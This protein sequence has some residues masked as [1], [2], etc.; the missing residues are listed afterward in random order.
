MRKKEEKIPLWNIPPAGPSGQAPKEHKFVV[1]DYFNSSAASPFM[2]G[3]PHWENFLCIVDKKYLPKL[4][5]KTEELLKK[6]KMSLGNLADSKAGMKFVYQ[7]K[8]SIKP[9]PKFFFCKKLGYITD[10]AIVYIFVDRNGNL[11]ASIREG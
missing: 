10:N 9:D 1:E 8:G 5:K 4:N 2:V 3:N 7:N 6:S 11:S